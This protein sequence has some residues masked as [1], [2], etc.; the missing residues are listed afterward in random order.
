MPFQEETKDFVIICAYDIRSI[1]EVEMI[2]HIDNEE[3]NTPAWSL[4]GNYAGQK[5]SL[6]VIILV[7]ANMGNTASAHGKPVMINKE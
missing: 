5:M 4:W 2:T 3:V 1:V 6:S 7:S